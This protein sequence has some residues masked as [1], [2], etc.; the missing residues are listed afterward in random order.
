MVELVEV[1][2]VEPAVHAPLTDTQAARL[3]LDDLYG[4]MYV[5]N[6]G[7]GRKKTFGQGFISISFRLG[8]FT[9]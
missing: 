2:Q 8:S 7:L 5:Q 4:S 9:Y 3:T 6:L 1:A